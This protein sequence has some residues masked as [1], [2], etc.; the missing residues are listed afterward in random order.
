MDV[1]HLFVLV[2]LTTAVMMGTLDNNHYQNSRELWAEP[3]KYL[4]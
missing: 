1:T 3:R 2:I 4:Q